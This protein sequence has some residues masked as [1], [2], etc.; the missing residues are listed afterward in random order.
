M[1]G[2]DYV[3]LYFEHWPK[4][5]K[6]NE[7][8]EIINKFPMHIVWPIMESLVEKGYTKYIGVSNYNVYKVY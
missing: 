1:L 4:F 7:K 5:Y 3:D 6:Y 8:G 2:L